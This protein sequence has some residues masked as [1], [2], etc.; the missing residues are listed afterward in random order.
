MSI[1][2]RFDTAL[3]ETVD[4]WKKKNQVNG[5]LVYG[6]YVRGTVT[7]NSDLDICI[8]WNKEDAPAKLLAEY[9]GTRIDMTFLSSQTVEDVLSKKTADSFVVAEVM[10]RFKGARIVYDTGGMLK[11][12]QERVS[13]F[14][15][16][17]NI[18]G[19]L[20]AQAVESLTNASRLL[21]QGEDSMSAT[22]VLRNGLFDLGQVLLMK[23]DIFCIIKP[24]EVLNEIRML[25]PM[26]YGLFL[27]TFK[28]K[29]LEEEDLRG[30][31][32]DVKH[33]IEIAEERLKKAT[34]DSPVTLLSQAQREYYGA[35]SLTLGGDY[36][37]A[38][39]EM[40]RS[41]QTVGLALLAIDGLTKVKR[42]AAVKELQQREGEFYDQVF[43]EYGS[44][45]FQQKEIARSIGEAQFVAQR[46]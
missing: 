40:R 3:S 35:M 41:V 29:G 2:K 28:L 9:K 6:S 10:C 44:I 26:T 25:D 12:W 11:K 21:E 31:L 8:I 4:E 42:E 1:R 15:W 38:V 30:I 20:K 5:I 23:N 46:L 36:E 34:G 32:G 16:P 19:A 18:V 39:F 7:A 45:D 22:Y 24:S 37:L 13:G 33:W 17:Q 27:R 14:K 43:V